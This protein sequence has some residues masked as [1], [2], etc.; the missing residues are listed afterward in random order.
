MTIVKLN[1][2]QKKQRFSRQKHRE[3]ER[4]VAPV[5]LGFVN[6]YL[7]TL[8]TKNKELIQS[9][10][11]LCDSRWRSF[12]IEWNAKATKIRELRETDFEDFIKD[13]LKKVKYE[14]NKAFWKKI[15]RIFSWR[16]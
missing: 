16:G 11:E 15:F 12:V 14:K 13:H 10:Y 1:P 3:M 6:E 4:Q 8:P 5:L 9:T 2:I 7:W